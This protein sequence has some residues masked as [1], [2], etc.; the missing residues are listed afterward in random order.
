MGSFRWPQSVT[1]RTVGDKVLAWSGDK[2]TSIKKHATP[3]NLHRSR[4]RRRKIENARYI[5]RSQSAL[6]KQKG[7][8]NSPQNP[9]TAR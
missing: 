2:Q 8:E 6:R 3:K 5:H 9:L 4:E 1:R 7:G